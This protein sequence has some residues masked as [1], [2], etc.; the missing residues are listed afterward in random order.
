[1]AAGRRRITLTVVRDVR[2]AH[3]AD[4]S[5]PELCPRT[6]SLPAWTRPGGV[7]RERAVMEGVHKRAGTG[8][9]TQDATYA[10]VAV[11]CLRGSEIMSS[12]RRSG[13]QHDPKCVAGACKFPGRKA[14]GIPCEKER[15]PNIMVIVIPIFEAIKTERPH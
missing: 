15:L 3:G 11:E 9:H 5:V 8:A 7:F 14:L 12:G 13:K 2:A 1:M 6:H 4:S 10:F